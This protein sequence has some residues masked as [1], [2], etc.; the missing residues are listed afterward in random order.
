MRYGIHLLFQSGNA[1]TIT[2]TPNGSFDYPKEMYEIAHD[3]ALFRMEFFVENQYHGRPGPDREFFALARD[4]QPNV[5]QQGGLQGYL[6]KRLAQFQGLTNIK[7]ARSSVQTN[8]GYKEM[9]DGFIDAILND[10]PTPCDE[11]AGY[12]AT[13]LGETAILRSDFTT[14][15]LFLRSPFL[16]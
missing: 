10:T 1:A 7:E 2:F 5:G 9:F 6:E 4:S 3:G 12:Q 8:H 14:F 11:M 16:Q 13:Y 15:Y